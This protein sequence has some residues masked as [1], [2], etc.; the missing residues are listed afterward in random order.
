MFLSQRLVRWAVEK[1]HGVCH[2]FLGITFLASKRAGMPIAATA[3]MSLDRITR[4]HLQKY[5][6][7]DPQSEFFFQPFK[8][9]RHWVTASYPSSGLQAIN[10][11]TFQDVFLHPRQTRS[12][13]FADGYVEAIRSKVAELAGYGTPSL[14]ALAVWVGKHHRWQ[15]DVD[16]AG[17]VSRF[18]QDFSLADDECAGLFNTTMKPPSFSPI[19]V[20][21]RIDLKEVAHSFAAPPDA[22]GRTEA[23]LTSIHL[24]NV[25]PAPEL[26]LDFGP[27]LT[28]IAGDNG[29]G[30]SFLLDVAWWAITGT[31]AALPA[32][33][34][35]TNGSRRPRIEYTIT[36]ARGGELSG[37]ADFAWRT[38]SWRQ[39]ASRPAVAAV[40]IYARADGSFA[41]A[42]G[43]RAR[44]ESDREL[45][46]WRFTKREVWNGKEGEIEGLVRDW[47]HWQL[48]GE[49]GP[50]AMLRRVLQHLS[51]DETY[52]LE[53][54]D[55]V[56]LPGDPKRIP[57]IRQMYAAVPIVLASAG[58]QRIL[59]VAYLMIW[60]WH[61]HVLAALQTNARPQTKM[62]IIVDELEAHLHPKWQRLVLPAL[63]SVGKL[64][65]DELEVQVIAA[66]HSPLVLASVEDDFSREADVLA[67]LSSLN[68]SVT[69]EEIDF[70]KYGD[71]S[72]W[73]TSPVFG[74]A[75]AR[76]R[77]GEQAIEAAKAVQLSV[78]PSPA[79]V[80]EI[81]ERLKRA[82][83]PDDPFWSRWIFFAQQT[84]ED[85]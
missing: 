64:L 41:I 42:D 50:F 14:V 61:E 4:Q 52:P 28:L 57:T 65:S 34:L 72:A 23:T 1:L 79:A 33:P 11:Q 19:A 74:L 39:R 16:V 80:A 59:T 38:Y 69:L 56:R 36:R 67:H 30:K 2:P 84:G 13:G 71:M 7:L 10:T 78:D 20:K 75:H 47:V 63:M 46:V 29:L 54:D 53:P 60:T 73:L 76:S 49:T 31:W 35:R 17:I 37:G 3:E 55:P 81:D 45:G 70:Y 22:P 6:R 8:S 43:T 66:T 9:S 85:G 51:P 62:V 26:H 24:V 40:N 68:D 25:G 15:A 21:E 77:S 58:V 5:H 83:G 44:L 18:R 27:R 32:Y 82:L 12:W 48:S